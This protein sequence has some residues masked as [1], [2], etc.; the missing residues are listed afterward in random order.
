M[1]KPVTA[2]ISCHLKDSTV[3]QILAA[4]G[5]RVPRPETFT[6]S[7]VERRIC[8]ISFG[9]VDSDPL[10]KLYATF[11]RLLPTLSRP[12]FAFTGVSTIVTA[13]HGHFLSANATQI[14][15]RAWRA[16]VD[17]L[18][19][20]RAVLAKAELNSR[21]YPPHAILGKIS[22]V[23][24]Y[25]ASQSFRTRIHFQA[26]HIALYVQCKDADHPVIYDRPFKLRPT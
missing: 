17:N 2:D 18:Q 16:F 3:Q 8:L 15:G 19:E 6:E 22:P 13:R 11:Q 7:S 1:E 9:A 10:V 25:I 14:A 23:H 4:L 5:D 12:T 24:G 20:E 21:V 26:S